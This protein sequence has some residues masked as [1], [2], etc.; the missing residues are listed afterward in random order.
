V[1]K[2]IILILPLFIAMSGCSI[3]NEKNDSSDNIISSTND[4]LYVKSVWITYYELQE[5]IA[6]TEKEFK[7]NIKNAFENLIDMGFNTVTIQVRPCAD[8]FYKSDYFPSSKYCFGKQGS[9]MPYDP[10]QIMCDVA[11]SVKINI[12]AWINPYRVSQDNK[13]DELCDDNIA[14]QWYNN[15][16]TKSYV[17][18]DESAIYFNPGVDEVNDLII[19]GVKEIVQ[20]YN[21]TAIHFDDYF[22]PTTQKSIDKSQYSEYKEQ[23]GKLSL[24]NWRREN[25]SNMIKSVYKAIKNVNSDVL[26][27]ISPASDIDNDYSKLYAD[28]E[29]WVSNDGYVDYIC[30]QIYFGF[31]NVYQPFMFTTKKWVSISK[32]DLYV[33]LPLYKCG[34]VDE[35]A[36]EN[37][38]QR[39][40]EFVDNNDIISRQI[41]YLSKIDE[42]KGFYIF[43]YSYL[44]KDDCKKEVENMLSV[45][46]NSN[47]D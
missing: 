22:Y 12:E 13:I 24:S 14:K 29:T 25:I 4:N 42:V 15:K 39:I 2:L 10:L 34:K 38:T 7:N 31:K 18:I 3:N 33:G 30:P 19:N 46:Q 8:A 28:V 23:G 32:C 27:G 1:K 21:I 9:D 35:Y 41:N 5:L 20:N 37:E 36:A 16:K 44:F 26:F 47:L 40:N 11:Q 45:M 6:D 43:S 17:Y